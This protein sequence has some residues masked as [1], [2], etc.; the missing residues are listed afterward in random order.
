M[1]LLR[2]DEAQIVRQLETLRPDLRVAFAG[3]CAQRLLSGIAFPSIEDSREMQMLQRAASQLWRHVLEADWQPESL[4]RELRECMVLI[5]IDEGSH[6]DEARFAYEDAVS[7]F[8]YAYRA[9]LSGAAQEAAWA[10]RRVYE[11]ADRAA[12]LETAPSSR[13]KEQESEILSHPVIQAE[14][15]REQKD[16]ESLQLLNKVSHDAAILIGLKQRA[17]VDGRGSFSRAGSNA[18]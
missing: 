5:P 11:A 10:A 9:A 15:T 3:L 12:L 13:G 4:E 2:F 8:A 14:L 6:P 1:T 7:S 16:L 17:E 18:D